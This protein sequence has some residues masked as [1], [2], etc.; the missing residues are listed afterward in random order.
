M[1]S[2]SIFDTNLDAVFSGQPGPVRH[3]LYPDKKPASHK[4]CHLAQFTGDPHE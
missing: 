1:V 4:K 2:K 3:R